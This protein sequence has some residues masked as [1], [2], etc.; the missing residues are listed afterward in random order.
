MDTQINNLINSAPSTLNTLN[1]IALALGNDANFSTTIINLLATKQPLLTSS[2]NV[3]INNLQCINEIA[4]KE[5]IL[6]H[7]NL[8]G[9]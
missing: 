1:E 4:G 7:L 5:L 2:S 6:I 9:F 3:S 8:I